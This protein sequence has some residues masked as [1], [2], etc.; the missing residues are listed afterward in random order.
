MEI[1][2]ISPDESLIIISPS[3]DPQVREQ[4]AKNIEGLLNA[5]RE[6]FEEEDEE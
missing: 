6:A 3:E 4:E 5:L 1:H 2:E